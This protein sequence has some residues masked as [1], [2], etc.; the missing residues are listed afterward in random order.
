[1]P[2]VQ[3]YCLKG[4]LGFDRLWPNGRA[5]SRA[6]LQSER[7]VKPKPAAKITTILSTRSGVG[8]SAVLGRHAAS[9]I[10]P[11]PVQSRIRLCVQ[12]LYQALDVWGEVT[13]VALL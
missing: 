5:L 3:P 1:L 6:A 11:N 2:I 4:E 13:T 8:Y 12:R 7:T 10:A 9:L